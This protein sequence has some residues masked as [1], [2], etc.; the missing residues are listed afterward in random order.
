MINW[1]T[2]QRENFT[3]WK[4][5]TAFLDIDEKKLLKNP[6]FPLNMPLRLAKKV[7]KKD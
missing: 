5:L 1:R 6:S 7:K 3:N 2:I 4:K